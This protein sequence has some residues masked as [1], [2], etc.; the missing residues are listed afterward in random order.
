MLFSTAYA[1][2]A[3]FEKTKCISLWNEKKIIQREILN[4]DDVYGKDRA[5]LWRAVESYPSDCKYDDVEFEMEE[6]QRVSYARGLQHS[7]V[8]AYCTYN[9]HITQHQGSTLGSFH[10]KKPRFIVQTS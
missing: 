7:Q 10:I 3:S 1:L 5:G 8:H 6:Q 4:E 9:E 2:H